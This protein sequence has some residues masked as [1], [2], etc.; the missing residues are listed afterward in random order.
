MVVVRQ[1]DLHDVA[2]VRY[3]NEQASGRPDEA[4]LV[5]T[6][7]KRQKVT[8]SLVAVQDDQVVEPTLR[9][10]V[11]QL[12]ISVIRTELEYPSLV[13]AVALFRE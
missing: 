3:V 9:T 12:A 1:E 5:V 4:D 13:G 10:G 7:R 6:L 2:A 8:L 11:K